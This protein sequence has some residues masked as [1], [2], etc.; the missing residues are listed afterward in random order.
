MK[1]ARIF[2]VAAFTALSAASS[3]SAQ[4]INI[5]PGGVSV[6]PT[7]PRERAIE[8]ERALERQDRR[9]SRDE[10]VQDRAYERG[11]RDGSAPRNCRTV[12]VREEDEDGNI[13]RRRV[14]Q[15]S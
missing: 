7:S 9:R 13:V 15:C 5:G 12:N 10:R 2:A 14:R 8:R 3:V 4:S 6:D 11:V 1:I